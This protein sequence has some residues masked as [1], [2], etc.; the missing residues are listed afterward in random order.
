MHP[1]P[2]FGSILLRV[3]L[4]LGIFVLG[5]FTMRRGLTL[6]SSNRLAA[7][8]K[9][10]VKTP[11]RGLLT[12]IIATLATQS[13]A[14]VT[15][16]SMG[17]VSAGVLAFADT[18][19]VI[20]GTNI[21]SSFTV[22]LLTLKLERF[23]PWLLAIGVAL[24]FAPKGRRK[25]ANGLAWMRPLAVALVGFGTIFAGFG[26]MSS[27]VRP[28]AEMPQITY[29]LTQAKQNPW[30]GVLAGTVVTAAVG[31]SSATTALTVGLAQSGALPIQGAL[32]IVFGNNVGTCATALLAA[33]G[34][35]RPVQ[36]VAATH[37][38]LNVAGA[39][40]FTLGLG[41]FT[42]LV[43]AGTSVPG[44]QVILGHILFN[45]LS[46]LAAL[47]FARGIARLL[48]SW[49]PDRVADPADRP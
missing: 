48:E 47:P 36:R 1:S 3:A 40:L 37:V 43:V 4:G 45:V 26:I 2:S 20:L 23:A 10:S 18:I 12:G 22:G 41:P 42:R 8:I 38:L 19:G 9:Q 6:A 11:A 21:G 14:A 28:I 17:L 32:A 44:E 5:L 39:A 29:W 27:A 30:L 13:S 16:T 49:L 15:I 24:F 7:R 31:S 35:S 34:G 46:S 33:I 25:S